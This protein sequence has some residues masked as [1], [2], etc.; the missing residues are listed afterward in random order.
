MRSEMP[1]LIGPTRGILSRRIRV[2]RRAS[3]LEPVVPPDVCLQ[4]P[5]TRWEITVDSLIRVVMNPE[6]ETYIRRSEKWPEEMAALRPI[7]LS[8]GLTEDM[9]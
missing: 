2:D 7:L 8:C 5:P 9:K 3:V 6:V 1:V 4:E